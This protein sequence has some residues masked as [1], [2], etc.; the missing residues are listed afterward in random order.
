MS[1]RHL[2]FHNFWLKVFSIAS[3]TIIWMA[4]HFSIHHD[5][6]LKENKPNSAGVEHTAP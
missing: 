3:G 4:I 2:I 1:L 6:S 5:L